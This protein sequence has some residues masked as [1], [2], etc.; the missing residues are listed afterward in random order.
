M[1]R[2]PREFSLK[3]FAL[4]FPQSFR[5]ERGSRIKFGGT[6]QESLTTPWMLTALRA[7]R[8]KHFLL[9]GYSTLVP[10]TAEKHTHG[11]T[12]RRGWSNLYVARK[13]WKWRRKH[14]SY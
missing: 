7:L 14:A 3:R 4:A 8:W 9:W 12:D 5:R 1:S 10:K 6:A 13:R 11:F 2:E